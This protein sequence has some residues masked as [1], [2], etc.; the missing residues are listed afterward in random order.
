MTLAIVAGMLGM[1]YASVPLYRL[2]CQVTGWGGTTQMVAVNPNTEI[3]TREVTVRFNTG[4][5]RNMPWAFKPDIRST[6]VRVGQDGIISFMA[7]NLSK[8]AITGTAVYNVTPLKA[9]KY[10]FKTEC[11]CF[12]EQVLNPG[13]KQHMPVTFFIDPAL[14][15]DPDMRDVDTITLSYTFF[16]KDSAELEKAIENFI[17]T[18]D[19]P[20]DAG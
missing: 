18:Q 20:N 8:T 5:A 11:F 12:G 9:G 14:A 2:L 13:E 15:D 10:F 19:N 16:R 7:E 4:T 6:R 3:G 17:E 1:A